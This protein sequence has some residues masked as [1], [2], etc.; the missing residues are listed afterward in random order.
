M[1][2]ATLDT[3]STASAM[4]LESL[5]WPTATVSKAHSGKMLHPNHSQL[6][7]SPIPHHTTARARVWMAS[8]PSPHQQQ[9]QQEEQLVAPPQP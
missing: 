1:A 6:G 5:S 2:I 4:A 3:L 7:Y 8:S 9:Q